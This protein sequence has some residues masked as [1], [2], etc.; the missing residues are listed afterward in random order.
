MFISYYDESGDDGYPSFSSPL[1]A[2]S[3]LYLYYLNWKDIHSNITEFRQQLK[4]D[5]GLPIKLEM[6]V[7]NFLL[8]KNPYK[9][10]GLSDDDR[11]TIIDLYCDLIAQLELRIV[12]VVINKNA[13]KT[14]EYSVL[15]NALTYSIQRV[16]NDLN[17]IDPAKKFMIITDEGR[18]G[19]MRKTARRIQRINYIPSKFGPYSYRREI[20]S[21]IEDPLPKDSKESYF[22]Q[23]SDLLAYIVYLYSIINLR[24]GAFPK[25]LPSQIDRDKVYN[26]M[27]RLRD[28]LNLE[29]SSSD[30]YGVVIYPK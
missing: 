10:F 12:N 19:K 24:V 8:N 21:L 9:E 25:R 3:S 13:I 1:F 28:S 22:I 23:L 6:H 16:E 29:A 11:I 14:S 30:E 7:K 17:K 4:K 20:K 26:W 15:D 2:L 18:V 5:F 27:G